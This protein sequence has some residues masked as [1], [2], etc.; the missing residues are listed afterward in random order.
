M[1]TI[2]GF[3]RSS[4]GRKSP[5]ARVMWRETELASLQRHV[6]FWLAC[7]GCGLL[8]P[9]SYD[10]SD[11]PLTVLGELVAGIALLNILILA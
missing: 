11:H 2:P 4:Q 7:R 5:F 1:A 10:R 8:E 9:L 6:V 3:P